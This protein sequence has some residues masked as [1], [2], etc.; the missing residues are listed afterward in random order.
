MK[1]F[2]AFSFELED[3]NVNDRTDMKDRFI[4]LL[5]SEII[6]QL[7]SWIGFVGTVKCNR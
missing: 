5:S 2:Q 7:N 6:M 1:C 3:E 4:E